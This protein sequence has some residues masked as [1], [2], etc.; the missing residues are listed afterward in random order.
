MKKSLEKLFF[1]SLVGVMLSGLYSEMTYIITV[2]ENHSQ[3]SVGE[4]HQS[5]GN[6]AKQR[7]EL[8]NKSNHKL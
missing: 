2:S 4:F 5:A 6:I 1:M 3:H 8:I 7:A